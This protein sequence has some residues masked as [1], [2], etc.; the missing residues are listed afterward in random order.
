M[1]RNRFQVVLAIAAVTVLGLRR[2]RM[3][4]VSFQLV[5][6]LDR[7]GGTSFDLRSFWQQSVLRA[8]LARE[9]AS[10]VVPELA[11]EAFLV[12]L[13]QECGILLIVQLLGDRYAELYRDGNLSPTA[14]Y[15]A[16]RKQFK[17]N[18]VEVIDARYPA[19]ECTARDARR[20]NIA[21]PPL[22]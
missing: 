17:Y 5:A 22:V 7:L 21:T 1:R 6:H 16:E 14:F 15:A 4:A 12:G 20:F 8:C 3:A 13:L 11:E 9:V 18:H 2:I 19:L 10:R